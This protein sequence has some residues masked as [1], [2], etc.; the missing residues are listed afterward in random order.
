MDN[1]QSLPWYG[2]LAF[3]LIVGIIVLVIY[4]ALFYTDGQSTITSLDKQIETVDMEIKRAEKKESQKK[5][6]EEE[7]TQKQKVLEDLMEVLPE[8]KEIAQIIRKVQ[9][10]VSSARLRIQNW[11]TQSDR[12][13][14]IYVEM[15]ISIIIEGNYHNLGTFFDQLSKL[16]KIFTVNNLSINPL[17]QMTTTFSISAAFTASTYTYREKEK[18]K[19]EK[20]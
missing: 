12:Q 6:I 3:F 8:D 4:Y 9:S 15:P 5:Q 7:I 13:K 14:E 1:I 17:P 2:Q 18:G 20:K 10:I 19:K 16:K 11:T